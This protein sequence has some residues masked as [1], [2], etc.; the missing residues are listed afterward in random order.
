[1]P[2]FNLLGAQ[3]SIKRDVSARMENK[4]FN[5]ARAMAFDWEYFDGPRVQGYGGYRYDGRWQAVAQRAI[6]RYQLKPGDRILDVGA[7]K[8]FL[9]AD[10]RTRYPVWRFGASISQTMPSA[11]A[12][13]PSRAGF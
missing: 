9:M 4:E 13:R 11:I 8:G 3:R 6:E 1:M 12:T 2:E 5:R 10:L 7:A